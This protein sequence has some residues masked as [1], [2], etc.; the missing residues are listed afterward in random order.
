M[1]LAGVEVE[2]DRSRLPFRILREVPEPVDRSRVPALLKAVLLRP[3]LFRVAAAWKSKV[4]PAW[5]SIVV[6]AALA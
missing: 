3:L 4:A 6:L 1:G 5:L 2:V